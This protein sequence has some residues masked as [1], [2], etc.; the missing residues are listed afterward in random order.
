MPEIGQLFNLHSPPAV[1]AGAGISLDQPSNLLDGRRFMEETLLRIASPDVDA[2]WALSIL[3][4]PRDGLRRPG[5]Y[6]RFETLMGSLSLNEIDADLH[7]LDCLDQCE[8]P[9]FNHYLL[10]GMV[11]AGMLVMTTNFDRLIE[12]A[13]AQLADPKARPLRVVHE[14]TDFAFEAARSDNRPTLWKLHGSVSVN[15]METRQSLQATMTSVMAHSMSEK[16]RSFLERVL[17][18]NDLLLVGYSGSDDFDI[19][20]VIC[21]TRSERRI[22]WIDHHSAA[23]SLTIRDARKFMEGSPTLRDSDVVGRNRVFFY[24]KESPETWMRAP[25]QLLLITVKTELFM[26]GLREVYLP[27]LQF[28][29][30]QG[31]YVFRQNPGKVREYFDRWVEQLQITGSPR[32][33]FF[34]DIFNN[35]AF[36]REQ[37]EPLRKVEGC[38]RK[39]GTIPNA[40]PSDRLDH[41]VKVFDEELMPTDDRSRRSSSLER[42]R[43]EVGSLLPR[44][45]VTKRLAASRLL[46]CITWQND[47][48]AAGGRLFSKSVRIARELGDF[49]QELETLLTWQMNVGGVRDY[50]S[51]REHQRCNEYARMMG[52]PEFPDE[53]HE[54]IRKLAEHAGFQALIW[55]RLLE[56]FAGGYVEE[57]PERINEIFDE[58]GRM[59]RFCVDVGDV[60]GEALSRFLLGQIL[61]DDGHVQHATFEFTYVLELNKI[62]DVLEYATRAAAYIDQMGTSEYARAIRPKLH[63]S[64]WNVRDAVETG[65]APR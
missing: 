27:D 40:T 17:R 65:P 35:R 55:R 47:G 59:I 29:T 63:Q 62:V 48:P 19:T 21:K 61:S 56:T 14:D 36:R 37:E 18:E 23:S 54:R 46:A 58:A 26:Q 52:E 11:R 39:L 10:A 4:L 57:D 50:L 3:D 64:I 45:S 44:L 53:A 28:P 32:Y 15:G 13:Y 30:V 7:V 12:I 22:L 38:L 9:N 31:E 41:L 8:H 6:L 34:L 42:S 33:K 60:R 43:R 20:P 51:P 1:L 24:Y 49:S 25:S 2:K 16:K 5:E